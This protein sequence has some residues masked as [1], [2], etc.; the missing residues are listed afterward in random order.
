MQS[1][2]LPKTATGKRP[3]PNQPQP[4][5]AML[6][7]NAWRGRRA[8]LHVPNA[9]AG[10]TSPKMLPVWRDQGEMDSLGNSDT[11]AEVFHN[12]AAP[13]GVAGGCIPGLAH[14]ELLS[15]GTALMQ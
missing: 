4:S 9:T 6:K 3:A 13:L 8:L 5:Q 11:L 15:V 10:D 7:N 1:P 2:S 12:N 14:Q